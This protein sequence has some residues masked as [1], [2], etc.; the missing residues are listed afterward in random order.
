MAALKF[1]SLQFKHLGKHAFKDNATYTAQAPSWFTTP[2]LGFWRWTGQVF[3]AFLAWPLQAARSEEH[4]SELQSLMYIVPSSYYDF[5][6]VTSNLV[7][8]PFD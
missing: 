3:N 6:L 4:T 2:P 8:F 7:S 5:I 1:L